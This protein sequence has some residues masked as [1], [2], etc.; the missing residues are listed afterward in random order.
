MSTVHLKFDV[1]PQRVWDALADPET[2]AD[3]VVGSHS[4]RDVEGSWPE[5]GSKFH[6][7]VGSGPFVVRDHTESLEADPPHRL[8]LHAKARPLGTARVELVI[9]KD[10]EGSVVTL[11]ETAGDPLTLLAI[12]RFT[13]PLLDR[14]NVESLRRLKRIAET[15]EVRS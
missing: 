10:G 2:Y 15:G 11:Q 14:R 7:R 3:W 13:N 1:P 12:N 9:A 5:P 4:I 6:H 8:V